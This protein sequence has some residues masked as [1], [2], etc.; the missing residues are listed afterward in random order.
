MKL[1]RRNS[2]GV[3]DRSEIERVKRAYRLSGRIDPVRRHHRTSKEPARVDFE[4]LPSA[5]AAATLDH[6]WCASARTGGSRVTS[7]TWSI[8]QASATRSVYGI[9]AVRRSARALQ[10]AEMFVYPSIYEGFGLPV[11]E[12]M[13]CGTPVVTGRPRRSRKSARRRSS[14]SQPIDARR[15]VTRWSG[16]PGAG[17]RRALAAPAA[18]APSEFSWHRAAR[19]SVEVYPRL[20]RCALTK[21]GVVD[22]ARARD[23]VDRAPDR[24]ASTCSF[25]QAY[26]LRFDAKLWQAQQ[27]Y[28]PLGALYAAAFVRER[29]YRVALVRRDARDS[30]RMSGQLRWIGTGRDSRSS[31][32]T[33]ST[34][35]RRCVCCAC[36][37][38]R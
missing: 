12:A 20:G 29:G 38:R 8:D 30:R 32:R 19:Q 10:P 31:T 6:R 11:I 28:A 2:A 26:F 9:R 1:R 13:A 21:V 4:R 16:S 3:T 5:G 7:R 36:G 37:R 33:T 14:T 15:S 17:P 22:R 27:P 35:C 25:G 18:A 23:P 34:T 24:T